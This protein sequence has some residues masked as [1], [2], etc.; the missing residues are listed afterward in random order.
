[1]LKNKKALVMSVLCAVASVGFVVSASAAEETMQGNLDEV[2]VEGSRD[3]LPGGM[4]KEITPVGI[5]GTQNIM[6]A[7]MTVTNLSQKAIT[8]FASPNTGLSDALSL[9]PSVRADRGGTYTD[10]SIRGIY[11]SGHSYYVNGIPGLLCQENIPYYWVDSASIISGPNLGV[12]A[13]AFSEAAAGTVNLTSKAATSEGNSDLK[14]T[15][16]GGSSMQEAVDVGRRF[17]END[18][19]GV[20]ITASNISGDTA[21]DGENLSQQAFSIN[22]DQKSDKSKSNLLIAY[23]H[24]EH[25]GGPGAF[26]FDT[27]VTSLPSAPDS[28]KIYKPDWSYNEYDNWIAALNHEQKLGEHISAYLNAGYHR[29][30]WYGYIDGNPKILNNSGDFSLSMTNYPLALTKKYMGIGVKGDFKIGEVKN[31]YL[32]GA[33]KTWYNYDLSKNPNF[34]NEIDSTT[35]KLTGNWIGTGNIYQHN[36]WPSVERPSYDAAHSQDAQMTGWHL[37]DTLKALDDRLQVTLGLHG[38]KA[39]KSPVGAAKQESDA[40]CPTFAASYK[41]SDAVTVYADHSESFGMGNMVA[42]NK[43]YANA[44]EILDPAKTKQNEI[45]VKVQTGNFLNT[46][47]AFQI[48]Q[49]NTVDKYENGKKYLRLDGE[50]K[51]KGFEWAFTGKLADKWDLIGGVMYLN[52]KDNKGNAVNG[53]SKWSGTVGGVYHATD[54]LSFIGRMTYLGS[55]TINDGTLDVPSYAKFDLGASYKTKLNNTPVTFDLMCYNLT[56]KDYWSA[57]SGASTLNLGAPRTV[58]LSANFEL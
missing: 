22:L 55:T 49:A 16:R 29:E 36:W 1:M 25:K 48:T 33:D 30:D 26:S 39:T 18:K 27:A 5:V 15:Y 52:A 19:Y 20:R 42:T 8:T 23:D 47:S 32:V 3:V 2:V 54:D 4:A 11:Q 41:V 9:D 14:I 53:A 51:N 10:I 28:S 35:G 6:S 45:G 12:N 17:G 13:T 7:P 31:E 43:D 21:I 34:G 46:F 44:G 40:I 56:G 58:V 57:R 38:H 37:V 24:T 50:Q